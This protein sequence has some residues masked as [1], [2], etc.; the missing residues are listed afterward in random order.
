MPEGRGIK[1]D[2]RMFMELP[3]AFGGL[4]LQTRPFSD[5]R[6]EGGPANGSLP[7]RA[8]RRARGG[9]P[10]APPDAE[11]SAQALFRRFQY[12]NATKRTSDSLL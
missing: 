1:P 5:G 12:M 4:P 8:A 11:P 7:T 9:R 6:S 2:H 10:A 3:G